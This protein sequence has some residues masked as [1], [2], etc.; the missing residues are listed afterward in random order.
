MANIIL[1][2]YQPFATNVGQPDP[3]QELRAKQEHGFWDS[4]GRAYDDGLSGHLMWRAEQDFSGGSKT[5]SILDEDPEFHQELLEGVEDRDERDFILNAGSSEEAIAR[6]QRVEH[7]YEQ[8][9]ALSETP[10]GRRMAIIS[11]FTDPVEL[12]VD[13]ASIAAVTA[14]TGGT[15]TAGVT[16]AKVGKKG[17][18]AFKTGLKVGIAEGAVS[19]AIQEQTNP[20]YTFKDA[21][22]EI[23]FS[24]LFT[25]VGSEIGHRMVK[26]GH[27]IKA[28]EAFRQGIPL[29]DIKNNV[30]DEAFEVFSEQYKI[31]E[32]LKSTEENLY[33]R[34]DNPEDFKDTPSSFNIQGLKFLREKLSPATYLLNSESNLV[35]EF[36]RRMFRVYGF[37]DNSTIR[38]SATEQ[39]KMYQDATHGRVVDALNNNFETWLKNPD[40]L[41]SELNPIFT[42]RTRLGGDRGVQS[43]VFYREVKKA[44]IDEEYFKQSP[45][46]VKDA[47]QKL[48]GIYE[49]FARDA[50]EAGVKGSQGMELGDYFTRSYDPA[51][52]SALIENYGREGLQKLFVQS[53]VSQIRKGGDVVTDMEKINK[54]AK[55]VSNILEDTLSP[56]NI[57]K[58]YHSKTLDDIMD[59]FDALFDKELTKLFDKEDLKELLPKLFKLSDGQEGKISNLKQRLRLD[60]TVDV[61]IFNKNNNRMEK[62]SFL[63]ITDNTIPDVLQKYAFRVGGEISLAKVGIDSIDG[64]SLDSFIDK[65]I[66][67]LQSKSVKSSKIEETI[68]LIR[69]S[70]RLLKGTYGRDQVSRKARNGLRHVRNF[71]YTTS[72]GMAGFAA[73][74]EL[75][76][77]VAELGFRNITNLPQMK[78]IIR[79]TKSGE[80]NHPL[81]NELSKASG[82][83]RDL[84]LGKNSNRLVGVEQ[85]LFDIEDKALETISDKVRMGV[86]K[87]SGLGYLTDLPRRMEMWHYADVMT[88]AAYSKGFKRAFKEGQSAQLGLTDEI[89]KDIYKNIRKY[90]KKR[91]GKPYSLGLSQWKDTD[92]GKAFML[93]N[94]RKVTGNVQESMAGSSPFFL[95]S[96]V[97]S[98]MGQF[99]SFPMAALEQ[100]L[101][102]QV[103]RMIRGEKAHITSLFLTATLFSTLA[104]VSRQ[105]IKALGMPKKKREEYLE[106]TLNPIAIASAGIGNSPIMSTLFLLANQTRSTAFIENPT[107]GLI[108]NVKKGSNVLTKPLMGDDATYSDYRAFTRLLPYNNI[109]GVHNALNK[110]SSYFSGE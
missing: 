1:E 52:L 79:L 84:Y 8:R 80:I 2:N 100:Q 65:V 70:H 82:L 4:V 56:S 28:E 40:K 44:V 23:I 91:K 64:V 90:G 104:Y 109:V 107:V 16:T 51:R 11:A 37:S 18:R 93:A 50:K 32:A 53:F 39:A 76:T 22:A 45:T 10:W 21:G 3:L 35:R 98:T 97:G 61:E 30:D 67:E 19:A 33:K 86:F 41:S 102:R 87:Y 78:Q 47:A 69:N 27:Q 26:R 29:E 81:V 96:P 34:L 66:K 105:H 74:A 101:V 25:G 95:R 71:N 59:D 110:L 75:G 108:N 54:I 14:L 42:R 94:H 89:Y 55:K 88:K 63:D 43:E 73:M 24:G 106:K 5:Y 9:E 77:T 62:V 38:M 15:G 49:E 92:A 36:S 85:E 46:E 99:L 72:M 31:D 6:K 12:S 7:I 13:L 103:Y 20:F 48:K 17:Y 68:K 83:G 58:Q 57:A 60:E